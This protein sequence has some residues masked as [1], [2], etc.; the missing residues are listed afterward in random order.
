VGAA[1]AAAT[2]LLARRDFA[3]GELAGKL[4]ASGL[5]PATVAVVLDE[6]TSERL[7]DDA[8]YAQN[9]IAYHAAR[10]QGPVRI[11][12][13]LRRHGLADGVIEAALT[14]GPDWHALARRARAAKFGPSAPGGWAERAR[15]GRFLQ[16][17]GFS[18]DHIRSATGADPEL[19]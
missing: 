18:S 19:E 17:R 12:A 15:Q 7:I 11:A 9:F 3:R 8:R 1:R 5:D 14:A 16:Y 4:T 6:L 2:A 10:G 13:E